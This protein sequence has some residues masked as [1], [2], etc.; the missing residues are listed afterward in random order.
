MFVFISCCV[1]DCED[2]CLNGLCSVCVCLAFCG[3]WVPL[4]DESLVNRS[5]WIDCEP[6]IVLHFVVMMLVCLC[7]CCPV[8][9]L[10]L[11]CLVHGLLA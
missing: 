9:I 1:V 3:E 11:V 4:C 6:M 10:F 8:S 5:N 7:E 2:F